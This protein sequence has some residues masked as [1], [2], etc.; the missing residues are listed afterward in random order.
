MRLGPVA[1]LVAVTALVLVAQGW[2]A[3]ADRLAA[4]LPARIDL[5]AVPGWHRVAYAPNPWWEPQAGGADHRL[6]GRYADAR[7]DVVDVFFALYASQGPGHKADG[8][9][10]GAVRRDSGWSWQAPGPILADATSDRL[11][12]ARPA[13]RLA[14]TTYAS[15]TLVT[16]SKLALRLHNLQDRLLLRAEPTALLI[17]SAQPAPGVAPER[18]IAAFRQA[19]GPLGPWLKQVAQERGR[20]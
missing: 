1:M 3:A 19:I 6:L 7:G 14:E 12:A 13:L 16:G 2:A 15:G 18:A 5:P 9:G 11:Q 20:R 17:L 10:E 8:T 4:P